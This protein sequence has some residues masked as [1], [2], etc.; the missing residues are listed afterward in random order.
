M[1]PLKKT[2][3]P[4]AVDT[5]G[6]VDGA[7]GATSPLALNGVA[8]GASANDGLAHQLGVYS[9]SNIA[10]VVF[11]ITGADADGVTLTETVTGVNNSTV[12]TTGYFLTVTSITI[13]ATLGAATV[14][15][16]WVDEFVTPTVR[17]NTYANG[18]NFKIGVTGTIDYDAEQTLSDIRTRADD[19]PFDWTAIPAGL[20]D[21]VD[22]IGVTASTTFRMVPPPQAI[23]LKANSYSSGAA[24]NLWIVHQQEL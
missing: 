1:R 20:V 4:T 6:I 3:T 24:L 12:E 9:S 17:L 14:D 15:I 7:T 23:R 16:G 11:T 13:S 10:T 22:V 8:A 2:Y 5:D 18:A 19:G 21:S